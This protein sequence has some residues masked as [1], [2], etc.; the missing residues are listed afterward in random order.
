MKVLGYSDRI[1]VAPAQTIKFMVSCDGPKTYRADIVRIRCGDENPAGPGYR[2][3][4]IETPVSGRYRGR[5]QAIHAGSYALVQARPPLDRLSSFTVQAMIWPT[6]PDKGE[7]VVT[8]KWFERG[9][10]GFEL[11]VDASG[12]VALKLGKGAG[13][14][15]IISAGK[16]LIA[17]EWYFA[18]ASYDADSGRVVVYQDHPGQR[19]DHA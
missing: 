15:Q 3:T 6:T 14:G 7:Q 17:R 4:P 16:P 12:A 13:R 9:K 10:S 2:E 19:E 11:I 8:G 18:G 1:S 5:K